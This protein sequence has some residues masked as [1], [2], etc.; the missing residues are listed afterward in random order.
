MLL[1]F[2]IVEYNINGV[3]LY[4]YKNFE[5]VLMMKE[6]K[7][8]L[9][10]LDV[11]EKSNNVLKRALSLA[12]EH[13]ADLFIVHAVKT[14]WLGVPSY[15]GSKD[16]GI[17]KEGIAKNIEKKIKP[18]NRE[19]NVNCFVFVKEGNPHDIILYE[20]KLN[21]VDMLIIG[22]HS[23]SK[24]RKSFLG[25]TAQKVAHQSHVPVL[26]VKNRVKNP[27]KNIIAPTDFEIQSKQ[28][29][30]FAKDVFPT[31][32]INIVNAFDTIYMEGPYA[33]V[34]RDL[35]Q[36]N[37]VA[38]ACAKDD[39]KEFMKDVDVK[40]GKV[41]D[42]ELY[43]KETLIDHIE[44]GSYDLVVIGSRGTTG[45]NAL[46]GSVATYIIRETSK[47]ILVYVP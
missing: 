9:V 27:Y 39:L 42:G 38:K 17:D 10:G 14:P 33:V 13:K 32:K 23:K 28:S 1:S 15:F 5:K 22:P 7:R 19:F 12:N 43:T 37:D 18:L 3:D 8:I 24:G 46:L 11:V 29:I 6:L 16:I 2:L 35:S 4:L 34:G 31:A 40:K 21:Q 20:A 30:L 45:M 26:I 44:E 25:T 36:Y 41:I 47:D